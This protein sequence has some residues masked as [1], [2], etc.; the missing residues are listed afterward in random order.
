[1]RSRRALTHWG[2]VHGLATLVLE[3]QLHGQHAVDAAM[4]AARL[5]EDGMMRAAGRAAT[6]RA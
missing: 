5:L 4:T 6:D 3:D 2:L 1:M